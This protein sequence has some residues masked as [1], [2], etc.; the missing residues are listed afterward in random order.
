M[1]HMVNNLSKA[2]SYAN[3]NTM[4]LVGLGML[5]FTQNGVWT[6]N[7]T[8]P[9]PRF[10]PVQGPVWENPNF[11]VG[12]SSGFALGRTCG[13][14]GLNRTAPR[15]LSTQVLEFVQQE[16][17]FDSYCTVKYK[18]CATVYLSVS[19]NNIFTLLQRCSDGR[20][21]C[22]CCGSH[23]FVVVSVVHPWWSLLQ[24]SS[25]RRHWSQCHWHRCC[26]G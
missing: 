7:R 13:G 18:L 8:G 17:Y 5:G 21:S 3:I 15:T 9:D 2:N 16:M 12:S 10:G 26:S 4:T 24:L 23:L 11:W 1:C 20:P 22:C 19:G 25:S 14:P 6:P